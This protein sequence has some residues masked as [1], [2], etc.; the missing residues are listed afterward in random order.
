MHRRAY[1]DGHGLF[2][3]ADYHERFPKSP[4]QTSGSFTC[5]KCWASQPVGKKYIERTSVNDLRVLRCQ[6]CNDGTV[7]AARV[8]GQ[9]AT[10]TSI[11]ARS[12]RAGL[13][14]VPFYA[15]LDRVALELLQPGLAPTQRATIFWRRANDGRSEAAGFYAYQYPGDQFDERDDAVAM[16]MPKLIALY[17]RPEFRGQG[18]GTELLRDFLGHQPVR[19]AKHVAVEGVTDE[20]LRLLARAVPADERKRFLEYKGD[21]FVRSLRLAL[22][23]RDRVASYVS[24]LER[25]VRRAAR[26]PALEPGPD[27]AAAAAGLLLVAGCGSCEPIPEGPD[28]CRSSDTLP[29][30]GPD[31]DDDPGQ[32]AVGPGDAAAVDALTKTYAAALQ[33]SEQDVTSPRKK[34]Q[35][36]VELTIMT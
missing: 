8:H 4:T 17:V 32:P 3:E 11:M 33:A 7:I 25:H 16:D 34:K 22:E 23:R 13:C 21:E 24:R 20:G 12:D 27:A 36:I 18:I 6:H 35:R 19:E 10:Y 31:D 9:W 2:C 15:N 1:W 5:H 30:A 26:T 28:G 14:E 29:A